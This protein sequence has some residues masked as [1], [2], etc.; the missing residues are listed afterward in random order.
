ME[1]QRVN[2]RMNIQWHQVA[3]SVKEEYPEEKKGQ[4]HSTD[5]PRTL[6]GA[7]QAPS[8]AEFGTEGEQA[9]S[10]PG[11]TE[12]VKPTTKGIV[13]RIKCQGEP[14]VARKRGDGL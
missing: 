9:W 13:G 8:Q 3:F 4:E 5:S 11:R 12:G 10:C 7:K 2:E 1:A 6:H 14:G